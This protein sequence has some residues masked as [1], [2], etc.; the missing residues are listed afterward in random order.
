MD[1]I[2]DKRRA[3]LGALLG[4]QGLKPGPVCKEAGLKSVNTLGKFLRG[5]SKTLSEKS[6]EAI[7]QVLGTN[8]AALDSDNPLSRTKIE[9]H[10]IIEEMTDAEAKE[11]LERLT[12]L[13]A[14]KSSS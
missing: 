1:N 14:S 7:M 2:W 9:L 11:E 12:A 8:L 3:N 4:Y 5:E 10:E 6:L 13:R